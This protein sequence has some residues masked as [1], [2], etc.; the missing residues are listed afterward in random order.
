MAFD[1]INEAFKKLDLLNEAMFDSSTEGIN[2]LTDYIRDDEDSDD[3]V[4]VIDPAA[5][6]EDDLQDSYIGKLIVNCNVCHSHIFMD[7]EDVQLDAEGYATSEDL[8]PYCGEQEG[9][10]IVGEIA[11]VKSSVEVSADMDEQ[12]SVE[13][14]D[15]EDADIFESLTEDFKE[16]SIT[17]DDQ[18]LEM[19]SDENG[20]VTVTTEPIT[21]E[22]VSTDDS[23]A[24]DESVPTD[25]TIVPVSDETTEEIVSDVVPAESSDAMETSESE[26]TLPEESPEGATEEP[27]EEHTEEESA[28]EPSEEAASEDSFEE[29]WDSK[30]TKNVD[31]S[32]IDEESIDELT[33]TYLKRVYENVS[34]FKTSSVGTDDHHLVIEGVLTFHSGAKKP[35]KFIFE[36]KDVNS[37]GQLRFVGKN[38]HLSES[39]DA[40]SIVGK[41][42]NSKLFLE[43]FKYNYSSQET[44]VRG[45][46]R[47]K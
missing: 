32:E 45:V 11:P 12:P 22:P 21:R 46:V 23:L 25:E 35:T 18:H 13:D 16:V 43:S 14:T 38:T 10:V 9:F 17:T 19:T 8:C 39:S 5:T 31:I 30:R 4:R 7:K 28:E 3:A 24:T 33:E 15:S 29:S 41:V 20:K 26:E 42:D 6:E 27:S 44:P 36:S 1:Y 47:R 37:R 2:H 34:S 40:F